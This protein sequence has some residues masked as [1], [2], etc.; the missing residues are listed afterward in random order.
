MTRHMTYL[1]DQGGEGRDVDT[2][3][4]WRGGEHPQ[5][6]KLGTDGLPAA[7]GSTNKHI[8]IGVVQRVEHCT[9]KYIVQ[10]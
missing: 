6:G 4:V 5:D 9:N 2:P 7:R 8:F 1:L 3:G 10:S